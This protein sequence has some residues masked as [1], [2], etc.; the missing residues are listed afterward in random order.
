MASDGPFQLPEELIWPASAGPAASHPSTD[1]DGD[2]PVSL[3]T[4]CH[5]S[6]GSGVDGD[7]EGIH[8]R[9][10]LEISQI[11]SRTS[12]LRRAPSLLSLG[13]AVHPSAMSASP[14]RT[15]SRYTPSVRSSR[16]S[17]CEPDLSIQLVESNRLSP[18]RQTPAVVLTPPPPD[19]TEE[20]L[21]KSCSSSVAEQMSV[22][23][24]AAPPKG[25]QDSP[26]HW[27]I[28]RRGSDEVVQDILRTVSPEGFESK[29]VKFLSVQLSGVATSSGSPY[30]VSP[31]SG[32]A[33]VEDQRGQNLR[34]YTKDLVDEYLADPDP[35]FHRSFNSPQQ[36]LTDVYIPHSSTS[37]KE[38]NVAHLRKDSLGYLPQIHSREV[39]ESSYHTSPPGSPSDIIQGYNSLLISGDESRGRSNSSVS[40]EKMLASRRAE[41]A[42][43]YGFKS[44]EDIPTPAKIILRRASHGDMAAPGSTDIR[45]ER[46]K[47]AVSESSRRYD[48][49]ALPSSVKAKV[50]ITGRLKPLLRQGS[51]YPTKCVTLTVP[52]FTAAEAFGE[53]TRAPQSA[54]TSLSCLLQRITNHAAESIRAIVGG[55]FETATAAATAAHSSAGFAGES[56]GGWGPAAQMQTHEEST[57]GARRDSHE[58]LWRE[59]ATA[60]SSL[61]ASPI[62][63][64]KPSL[65]TS[66]SGEGLPPPDEGD[67]LVE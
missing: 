55:N 26:P 11:P 50:D 67:E 1:E 38:F 12:S 2:G 41:S 64:R 35:T 40:A 9:N 3:P 6:F 65:W 24:L 44:R 52:V 34:L 46:P 39:S 23:S 42:D 14:G 25:P 10:S 48:M 19:E 66:G 4:L 62:W 60:S 27:Q 56:W 32:Q 58:T 63:S 18:G 13:A 15:A 53:I 45:P 22:C 36:P 21:E 37:S 57:E 33:P 17:L 5:D 20:E 29:C 59:D 51:I 47:D 8:T 16:I 54:T 28:G 30:D 31:G 7:S 61:M 43:R 49:D